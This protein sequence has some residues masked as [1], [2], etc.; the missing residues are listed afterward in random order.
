[1]PNIEISEDTFKLLCELQQNE[2]VATVGELV[3]RLAERGALKIGVSIESDSV[4]QNEEADSSIE[5]NLDSVGKAFHSSKASQMRLESG[6][7]GEFEELTLAIPDLDHIVPTVLTEF[8]SKDLVNVEVVMA[9][10]DGKRFYHKRW[11]QTL[12]H[13]IELLL[14]RGVG[15][16]EIVDKL[17]GFATVGKNLEDFLSY[18]E[19]LDISHKIQN[20]KFV[21]P[22]IE[23]LSRFWEVDVEIHF[24]WENNARL[25]LRGLSAELKT[26]RQVEHK[27]K[28]KNDL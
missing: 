6:Q 12:F 2:K 23:N 26:N 5:A 18:N 10:V 15:L 28:R 19:E 3:E 25:E 4:Y 11:N 22:L 16:D 1:M 20:P 17:Q 24:K 27:F 9:Y 21:W 14:G 8:R 7:E 13:V